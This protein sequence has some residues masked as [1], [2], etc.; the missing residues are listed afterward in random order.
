MTPVEAGLARPL[1]DALKSE[2]VG[3][4]TPLAGI[5]NA[6]LTFEAAVREAPA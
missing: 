3:K 2:M 5:N 6:P 1:V 4:R